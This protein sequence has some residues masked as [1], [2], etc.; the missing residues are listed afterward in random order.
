MFRRLYESF[1]GRAPVDTPDPVTVVPIGTTVAQT[2]Q[3][4]GPTDGTQPPSGVQGNGSN[5]GTQT[6]VSASD[7]T[8]AGIGMTRVGVHAPHGVVEGSSVGQGNPAASN[9]QLQHQ[10]TGPPSSIESNDIEALRERVR[11]LDMKYEEFRVRH[12]TLGYSASDSGHSGIGK[13][14]AK[15]H[16]SS[17]QTRFSDPS[18]HSTPHHPS[19]PTKPEFKGYVPPRDPPVWKYHQDPQGDD[20]SDNIM[21]AYPSDG[22]YRPSTGPEFPLGGYEQSLGSQQPGG[23]D[24]PSP[25]QSGQMAGTLIRP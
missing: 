6:Q 12:S 23:Y 10:G 25:S 24:Y 14:P 8:A 4:V 21:G 11:L 18:S 15:P 20:L 3:T 5:A 13:A 22:R 16:A 1:S 9:T 7:S 19:G 2:T 17:K